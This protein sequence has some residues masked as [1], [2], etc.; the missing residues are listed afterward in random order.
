MSALLDVN[1]LIVGRRSF[2]AYT[3]HEMVRRSCSQRLG[4][5]PDHAEWLHAHHVPSGLSERAAGTI[6]DG[7]PCGSERKR[8]PPILGR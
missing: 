6:G 8:I 4:V 7:S 5:L 3:R 1:V 2:A